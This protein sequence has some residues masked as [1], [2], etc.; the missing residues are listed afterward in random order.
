M[1]IDDNYLAHHG[2][3]G[4]KWGVRKE[5]EKT[6]SRKGR[7]KRGHELSRKKSEKA[8]QI[9]NSRIKK[10][11]EIDKLYKKQAFLLKKYG[12]DA[13]D[14]GGGNTDIWSEQQLQRAGA[15]YMNIW[16]DIDML[17]QEH[18]KVARS[19]S[20]KWLVKNYG[21]TALEDIEYSSSIDTGI[22]FLSI[23]G[24]YAGAMTLAIKG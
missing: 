4:M 21:D 22:A 10:D 1:Y 20:E 9:Y 16:D 23:I 7:Y 11:K 5:R 24:L 14:G 12:L 3:K 2:V 15:K 13:D 8:K 6:G 17:Q 19:E 18:W